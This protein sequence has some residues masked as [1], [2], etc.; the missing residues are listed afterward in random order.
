MSPSPTANVTFLGTRPAEIVDDDML[1]DNFRAISQKFTELQRL[2][3]DGTLSRE[4][5][6]TQLR[7]LRVSDEDGFEWT[8]GATTRR[9]FRRTGEGTWIAAIPPSIP[10][11]PSELVVDEQT[12]RWAERDSNA[13][14]A[15]PADIAP[16]PKADDDTTQ[17]SHDFAE[18]GPGQVVDLP[19]VPAPLVTAAAPLASDAAPAEGPAANSGVAVPD[20]PTA[21]L[22]PDDPGAGGPAAPIEEP[23]TEEPPAPRSWWQREIAAEPPIDHDGENLAPNP[24]SGY[25]A[26]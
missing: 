20:G 6:A 15:K 1:L 26:L 21:D 9:W 24:S 7:G 22:I 10:V 14:F 12:R 13:S 5:F 19:E 11:A 8:L 4:Q 16:T 2:Y 25:G 17:F 3:E 18:T 23:P